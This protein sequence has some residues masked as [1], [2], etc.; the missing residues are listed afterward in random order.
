M[1]S[2]SYRLGHAVGEVLAVA[3]IG[4]LTGALLGGAALALLSVAGL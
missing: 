1:K 2:L 4:T 3:V